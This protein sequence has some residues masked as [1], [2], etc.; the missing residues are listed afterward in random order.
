MFAIILS[1]SVQFGKDFELGLRFKPRFLPFGI[2]SWSFN[3]PR[4]LPSLSRQAL[5]H[6]EFSRAVVL[7]RVKVVDSRALEFDGLPWPITTRAV[8]TDILHFRAR[9][10]AVYGQGMFMGNL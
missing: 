3:A 7:L 2:S 8:S 1:R 6:S 9:V 10:L 5:H 4:S